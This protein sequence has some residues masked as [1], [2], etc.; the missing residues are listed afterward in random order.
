MKSHLTATD[1]CKGD[2]HGK[3]EINIKINH[4]GE[5]NR[6]RYMPQNPFILA[7][8]SPSS[9]VFVFDISKHPSLPRDRNFRPEHRCLG[10]TKEGYGLS[11]NPHVLGELLSGSDDCSI[12]LWD[13]NQTSTTSVPALNTW[14]GHDDVVEDVA[15]HA[16]SPHVFGSVGDD[17]QILMWDTRNK[18]SADPFIRV[19][20]A[21]RA[22]IHSINFNPHHEFLLATGSADETIKIWD[23]RNTSEAVHKLDGHS[24][25]VFQLQ[26]APFDAS[27]LASCGADRRV[28]VWDLTKV[29]MQPS[30][31]ADSECQEELLFIHGGHNDKVSDISWNPT[32]D[33]MVASVSDDNIL[34]VWQMGKEI[35]SLQ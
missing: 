32:Q 6:A 21:H 24:R 11:W 19:A 31:S 5:I 26:W 17:R 28:R 14:K 20:D 16:Y 2:T 9:D 34:Q 15:W 29:G 22:D 3:M 27:V 13:I 33:W 1:L 8:K 18:G 10:H 35:R 25:E 30:I 4:E 23:M 12:C 7:T